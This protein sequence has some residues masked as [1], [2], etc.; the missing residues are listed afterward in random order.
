M[1]LDKSSPQWKATPLWVK[2]G[3]FGIS[4]RKFARILEV[5]SLV[6][7]LHGLIFFFMTTDLARLSTLLFWLGAYWIS[8]SCRYIDNH[9][10]W[11][12]FAHAISP[13]RDS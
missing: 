11:L 5:I 12:V 8:A 6:A 9:E 3:M 4:S 10:L 2:V 7:G 1:L 13:S